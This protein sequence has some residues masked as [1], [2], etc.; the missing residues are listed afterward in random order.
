MRQK[1]NRNH[2]EQIL[3]TLLTFV[4]LA[5]SS[6]VMGI[7]FGL[8]ASFI[9]K[10]INMNDNPVRECLIILS[11]GYLAYLTAES[12]HFSGI[13]TMFS[14]GFTM[15]HYAYYNICTEAQKGSIIAVEVVSQYAESFLYVYLGICAYSINREFIIPEFIYLVLFATI[16]A[17]MISVFLPICA[18]YMMR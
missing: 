9:L 3:E 16:A 12:L 11:T 13:M 14:C 4:Y 18:I 6:L 2:S 7:C 1:Q 5:L 8:S 15:S 10:K 17:R